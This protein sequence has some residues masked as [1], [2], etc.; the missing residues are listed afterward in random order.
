MSPPCKVHR[1]AQKE[2]RSKF[3]DKSYF[4]VQFRCF[5]LTVRAET[6]SAVIRVSME[7]IQNSWVMREYVWSENCHSLERSYHLGQTYHGYSQSVGIFFS[8]KCEM[9]RFHFF[10]L[11]LVCFEWQFH[12]TFPEQAL[13]KHL[14]R[15]HLTEIC[16]INLIRCRMC[17][18]T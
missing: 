12:G 3:M 2:K 10:F 15:S 5:P 13:Q 16:L 14:G 9:G 8:S 1:W 4:S 11:I 18:R 7:M 17:L 6:V